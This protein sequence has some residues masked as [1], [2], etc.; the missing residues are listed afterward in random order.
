MLW[1][2]SAGTAGKSAFWAGPSRKGI[3]WCTLASIDEILPIIELDAKHTAFINERLAGW[4]RSYFYLHRIV[5]YVLGSFIIAGL[6]GLT[7]G[8]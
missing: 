2:G 8:T 7:Q 4:R 3:G 6:A 5:A 1:S